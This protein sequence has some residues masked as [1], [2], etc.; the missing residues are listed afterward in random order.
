MSTINLILQNESQRECILICCSELESIL[1]NGVQCGT[2]TELSG[3]PFTG[4]T[5]IW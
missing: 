4:K 3:A 2:I 1:E 5:Q